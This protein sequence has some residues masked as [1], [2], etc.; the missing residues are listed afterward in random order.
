MKDNQ[1]PVSIKFVG[2]GIVFDLNGYFS[3]DIRADEFPEIFKRILQYFGDNEGISLIMPKLPAIKNVLHGLL[4]EVSTPGIATII[5]LLN[6]E[7]GEDRITIQYTKAVSKEKSVIRIES[8]HSTRT[9]I[10]LVLENFVMDAILKG[11][12]PKEIEVPDIVNV[13][14]P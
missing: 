6:G 5:L 12:S 2:S 14:L 10:G 13:I 7:P 9:W 4:I 1:L 11:P 3:K 8:I